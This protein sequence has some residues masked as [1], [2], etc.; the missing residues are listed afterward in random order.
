VNLLKITISNY[1]NDAIYEQIFKQIREQILNEKLS[2]G[3]LLPSIR[4]LAQELRI[5]VIT[6]KRAYDELEREG[7]IETV[8]GKGSFVAA[9][10]KNLLKERKMSL[11]ESK[12]SEAID[13]AKLMDINLEELIKLIKF[14]Y[15]GDI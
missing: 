10:N 15:R 6:T 9:Q 12:L 8:K 5:S 11:I 1:S 4:K 3:Y 2:Q 14:L 13:E 7:L